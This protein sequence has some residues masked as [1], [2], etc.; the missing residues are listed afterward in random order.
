MINE[1]LDETVLVK[2]S[3]L[4]LIPWELFSNAKR[5]LATKKINH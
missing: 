5:C 4:L 3:S 2:M 1:F